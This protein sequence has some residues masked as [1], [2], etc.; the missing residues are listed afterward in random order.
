MERYAF[1]YATIACKMHGFGLLFG[2]F[3]TQTCSDNLT[4][5][6][7]LLDYVLQWRTSS[8]AETRAESRGTLCNATSEHQTLPSDAVMNIKI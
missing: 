7:L 2:F 4:K 1:L 5:K 3:F 8:V 6:F